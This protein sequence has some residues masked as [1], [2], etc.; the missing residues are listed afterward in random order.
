MDVALEAVRRVRGMSST[1]EATNDATKSRWSALIV[2]CLGALLIVLDSTIVSVALPSVSADLHI[3]DSA[4][5]WLLNAYMVP[6][7]GFLL[8]AGRLGDF[9][10]QRRLFLVGL[11][12]FVVASAVCGVARTQ[13]ILLIGRAI[14]G[15]SGAVVSAVSLSSLIS[16]FC[17]PSE[18]VRALAFY[19][20]VGAA[21]G[22]LGELLGGVLVKLFGWQSIF[23]INIPIGCTVYAFALRQLPGDSISHRYTAPGVGSGLSITAS[24]AMAVYVLG[25]GSEVGWLSPRTAV[26]TPVAAMLFVLFLTLESRG[27]NPL[28]PRE[29][30]HTR[31]F[32]TANVVAALW[33]AGAFSWLMLVALFLQRVLAYDP[34]RVGLALLPSTIIIAAFSGRLSAWIVVRFGVRLPLVTGLLLV[35][36]GLSWFSRC[37]ATGVFVV[38]LLPGML[39]Q[40]LGSA[41]AY[42]PLLFLATRDVEVNES[43]LAS[44]ILNTSLSMGGT[45]GIG[46]L[47]SLINARA[48]IL[49]LSGVPP[50][51][52][53]LGGYHAAF[54][55]SS[56][57]VG[58]AAVLGGVLAKT[59]SE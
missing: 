8:L 29:L 4:L 15:T 56:L 37:P 52:A 14:Q 54:V 59:R 26:C 2:L 55:G 25:S 32:A 10:G 45:L 11:G 58:A 24:L 31:N 23:L 38:D 27:D 57:L 44:G 13:A 47:P 17:A 33:A 18:R 35:A 50:S 21:G 6:F 40:G 39:L 7:G 19:G 5:S 53:L 28:M 41:I 34:L 30:F 36:V 42:T 43:G 49:T 16:L 51:I 3:P 1:V 9:L 20:F 22:S 12:G 46:L 48:S